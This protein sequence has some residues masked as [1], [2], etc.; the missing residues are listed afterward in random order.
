MKYVIKWYSFNTCIYFSGKKI[1]IGCLE[2]G[3]DEIQTEHVFTAT[4]SIQLSKTI[5]TF[6]DMKICF[7]TVPGY[8]AYRD[9]EHGSWYVS[10]LCTVFAQSAHD[11]H[12][13][14]LLKMVGNHLSEQRSEKHE[15]QTSSNEDRGFNKTLY[16]NPGY[17]E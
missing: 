11:C 15:M 9:K 14:E 5:P 1:D 16:F 7:A 17:Y 3:S 4:D 12:L 10:V 8:Y 6:Y 2:N 13:E